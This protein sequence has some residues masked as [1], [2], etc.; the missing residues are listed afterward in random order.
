[1]KCASSQETALTEENIRI[2][3]R[4]VPKF[5]GANL[6]RREKIVEE[7]ADRI[8]SRRAEGIE[9]GRDTLID[10]CDFS[11]KLDNSHTFLAYS[12]ISVRKS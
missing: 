7:I 8:E 3:D 9:L 12:R 11:A 4:W 2:L 6:N 1:M 10:V 5:R